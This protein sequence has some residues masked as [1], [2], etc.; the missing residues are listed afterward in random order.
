MRDIGTRVTILVAVLTWHFSTIT[1][2][3]HLYPFHDFRPSSVTTL[4]LPAHHQN[5][6][7]NF[8]IHLSPRVFVASHE[9]ALQKLFELFQVPGKF[10]RGQYMRT[11]DGGKEVTRSISEHPTWSGNKVTADA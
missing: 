3:S 10:E 11:L 5:C 4:F 7:I 9:L 6:V 8:Y 2:T 1:L